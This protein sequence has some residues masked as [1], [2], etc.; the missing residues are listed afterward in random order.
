MRRGR[1]N[2]IKNPENDPERVV[3][4]PNGIKNPE[5]D[6]ERVAV[7]TKGEMSGEELLV[8]EDRS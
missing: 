3:G 1:P 2:W 8:S 6:P 5:N 4:R 7:A